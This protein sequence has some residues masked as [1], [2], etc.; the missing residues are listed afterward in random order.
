MKLFFS[1]LLFFTIIGCTD[2]DHCDD[3]PINYKYSIEN[4]SGTKVEIIP[5]IFDASG[6]SAPDVANKI[7]IENL[8]SFLKEYN[9][10][11]PYHGFSFVNVFN[12]SKVDIVF[13]NSKKVT[14]ESCGN[15][16]NPCADV[17]N[18]FHPANNDEKTET[19]ILSIDDFQNAIDCNGN[20][21]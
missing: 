7:T 5:Y 21:Y 10:G 6:V 19:Y 11:A 4:K 2:C 13:N 15:S 12:S 9:D 20:C 17:R 8:Q 16:T 14:Y 18:I 3:P 1:S